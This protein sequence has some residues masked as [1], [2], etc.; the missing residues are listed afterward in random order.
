VTPINNTPGTQYYGT[1][2]VQM[3]LANG[4]T[5]SVAYSNGVNPLQNQYVLGP[6]LWTSNASLFKAF[7]VREGQYLR[8]NADFFNVL[9]QPGLNLPDAGT[10]VISKQN[11]AQA[12]RQ[13]QLT[14]RYT[15]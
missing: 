6:M 10:G 8:F 12:P 14:L 1:N 4:T 11:S 9:N 3:T 15:W 2:T 5:Q 13:L 7:R